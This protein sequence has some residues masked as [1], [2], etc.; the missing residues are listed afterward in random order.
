MSGAGRARRHPRQAR[1]PRPGA[2]APL[3]KSPTASGSWYHCG[4]RM[5]YGVGVGVGGGRTGRA[6]PTA[7]ADGTGRLPLWLRDWDL[8]PADSPEAVS[9]P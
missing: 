9:D 4:L 3:S 8:P 5:G 2:T 6:L 7:G 1:S